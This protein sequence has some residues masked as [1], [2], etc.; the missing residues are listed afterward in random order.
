M[1]PKVRIRVIKFFQQLLMTLPSLNG[2]QE[3]ICLF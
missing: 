1:L 2:F 3:S